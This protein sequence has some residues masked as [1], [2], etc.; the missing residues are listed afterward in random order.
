MLLNKG[1]MISNVKNV[2]QVLSV[3]KYTAIALVSS[4]LFLSTIIYFTN[5]EI[6]LG[7]LGIAHTITYLLLNVLVALLFGIYLALLTS[8]LQ[9]KKSFSLKK[10]GIGAI[11]TGSSVLV[12][13]C[14]SCSVTLA[15]YLGLAS[16]LTALP[17]Y[18]LEF[19]AAGALLLSYSVKK[20]SDDKPK[21]CK[22]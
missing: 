9:L 12:T 18:G 3:G 2:W 15:S 19:N 14:V 22:V 17:F 13:G 7:N 1:K 11:G 10:S 6:M 4:I 5:F 8:S 20:L 21:T 16:V